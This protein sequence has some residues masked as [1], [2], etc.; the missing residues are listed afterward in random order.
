MGFGC[1]L[2]TEGIESVDGATGYLSNFTGKLQKQKVHRQIREYVG[3]GDLLRNR[4]WTRIGRGDWW[5]RSCADV[6][7]NVRR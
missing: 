6:S 7:A 1:L 5:D 4:D 3:A 2:A